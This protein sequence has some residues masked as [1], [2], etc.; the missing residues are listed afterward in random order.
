VKKLILFLICIALL[1]LTLTFTGCTDEKEV[2][3]FRK[4][5]DFN[6]VLILKGGQ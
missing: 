6:S 2:M 5:H 1:I 3:V 4:D